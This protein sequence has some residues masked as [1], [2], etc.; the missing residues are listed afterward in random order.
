MCGRYRL[1]RRKQVVEKHFDCPSHE[2]ATVNAAEL[3]G[4]ADRVGEVSQGHFA[5]LIEVEG[6]PL[7]DVKVLENVKFVMKGGVIA[8]NEMR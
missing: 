5:D 6:D 8:K 3:L 1:S 2:P 7:S 4:S